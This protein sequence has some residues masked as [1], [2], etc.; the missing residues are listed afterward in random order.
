MLNQNSFFLLNITFP[1]LATPFQSVRNRRIQQPARE[2]T[3][4]RSGIPIPLE[5]SGFSLSTAFLKYCS[6]ELITAFECKNQ[7][8]KIVLKFFLIIILHFFMKLY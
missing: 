8:N 2:A 7:N 1:E 6:A 5:M 4:W 3:S